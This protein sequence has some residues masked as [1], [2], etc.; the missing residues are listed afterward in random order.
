[1][2]ELDDTDRQIL[3]ILAKDAR[4]PVKT[5]AAQVGLSRSAT[6]ER[7]ANLERAGVIRGYRADIGE[8]NANAIRAFLLV[9]LKR[10]PANQ[11]LDLLAQHA[12]VR[13]VSSVTGELDLVVEIE[14]GNI[15]AVNRVRDL[16]ANYEMVDDLTTAVVLR[17]NIDREIR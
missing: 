5:L 12:E 16:I 11:L 13:R 8:I 7:V 10:T 15:D 2:R 6:S 17:R 1:M 3:T 4:I 14:A 9:R